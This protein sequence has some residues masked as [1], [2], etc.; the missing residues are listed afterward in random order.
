MKRSLYRVFCFFKLRLAV[1][2]FAFDLKTGLFHFRH[3]ASGSDRWTKFCHTHKFSNPDLTPILLQVDLLSVWTHG[4]FFCL[5]HARIFWIIRLG[6][7]IVVLTVSI[8][9]LAVFV[10]WCFN[11]RSWLCLIFIDL[12]VKQ[13]VLWKN[14]PVSERFV[15]FYWVENGRICSAHRIK[16][17]N[18]KTIERIAKKHNKLFPF[19]RGGLVGCLIPYVRDQQ[20]PSEHNID[21]EHLDICFSRV[22]W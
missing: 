4:V 1:K 9:L 21:E 7:I 18:L 5:L 15:Q 12:G 3:I 10:I 19:P 20:E 8:S 11:L 6:E 16:R 14:F 13:D 2:D 17:I 22:L